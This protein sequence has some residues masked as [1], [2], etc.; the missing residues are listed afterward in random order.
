MVHGD[1]HS[2]QQ[3]PSGVMSLLHVELVNKPSNDWIEWKRSNP[4]IGRL[5]FEETRK[6]TR[7]AGGEN[8]DRDK[9]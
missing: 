6:K 8:S 1:E 4:C 5:S 3:F 9:I 2:I 7:M